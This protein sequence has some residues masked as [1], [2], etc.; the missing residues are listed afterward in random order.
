MTGRAGEWPVAE[1][2]D[3]EPSDEQGQQHLELTRVQARFRVTLGSIR[4][5]LE[6]QPSPVCVRA[7]AR[8]WTDA[9]AQI[10]DELTKQLRDTG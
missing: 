6:E 5:D 7:A 3:L 9:I 2:V 10:T 1:P 4:A 8:R